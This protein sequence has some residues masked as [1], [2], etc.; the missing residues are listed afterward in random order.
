MNDIPSQHWLENHIITEHDFTDGKSFIYKV[1][2]SIDSCAEVLGEIAKKISYMKD[3]AIFA[4]IN[5]KEELTPK[6]WQDKYI[7]PIEDVLFAIESEM[8]LAIESVEKENK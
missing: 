3:M 7:D 6:Q 8:Q 2:K 1:C 4:I 5:E